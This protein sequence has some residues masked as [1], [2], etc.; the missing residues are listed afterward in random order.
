MAQQYRKKPVE[1]EAIQFKLG[2]TSKTELLEFCPAA[3]IGTPAN[4]LFDIRWF[5]VPH[6]D[7]GGEVVVHNDYIVKD[8]DGEFSVFT[9]EHFYKT[10]ELVEG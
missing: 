10:Y 7:G 4:D 3:N 6:P 8:E 2:R 1:V 9:S 5:V